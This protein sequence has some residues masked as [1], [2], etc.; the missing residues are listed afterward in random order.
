MLKPGAVHERVGA[1]LLFQAEAQLDGRLHGSDLRHRDGA[2]EVRGRDSIRREALAESRLA[3]LDEFFHPR[4]SPLRL[5]VQRSKLRHVGQRGGISPHDAHLRVAV[6]FRV[7]E[8]LLRERQRRLRHRDATGEEPL[9]D[10][11]HRANPLRLG[12]VLVP[13]HLPVPIEQS[14]APHPEFI[15]AYPGVIEVDPRGLLTHVAGDDA[16][17][18]STCLG[19]ANVDEKRV[20]SSIDS[21]DA[22]ARDAHRLLRGESLG[23]PVLVRAVGGG[24][25][26]EGLK[27]R[28]PLGEGVDD[29]AGVDPGE[30]LGEAEAAELARALDGVELGELL[31]SAEGDHG[32]GEEVELHG[33]T[34]PETRAV[35][36]GVLRQQ[37]MGE[38]ELARVVADVGELEGGAG[39]Q[40]AEERR[41]VGVGDPVRTKIRDLGGERPRPGTRLVRGRRGRAVRGRAVRPRRRHHLAGV[42]VST[43][44][45]RTG[46]NAKKD[47]PPDRA[48]SDAPSRPNL[49]P[50]ASVRSRRDPRSRRTLARRPERRRWV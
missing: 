34:D 18:E 35:V 13:H 50:T 37:A 20:R 10:H 46:N 28:V 9:A 16:G 26:D 45:R 39:D 33:E 1:H 32:A 15:E 17:D 44:H 43:D 23:D 11:V 14:I 41:R 48:R 12:H 19:A 3:R 24:V 21:P 30:S 38:E 36:G 47:G 4:Q 40:R 27:L 31:G 6:S 29:E 42:R 49:D 25:N 2:G 5:L 8:E 7:R 22:K